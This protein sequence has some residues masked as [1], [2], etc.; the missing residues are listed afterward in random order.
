MGCNNTVDC[1]GL[2]HTHYRTVH[3][4]NRVCSVEDCGK[5]VQHGGL[6]NWHYKKYL[7]KGKT[8]SRHGCDAVVS[9]I[10][11]CYTHYMYVLNEGKVCSLDDCNDPVHRAGMCTTHHSRLRK[12]G[13]PL[14][15]G[16]NG[17]ASDDSAFVYLV[18]SSDYHAFKIG[19]G[20]DGSG[21]L[22]KHFRY[23]WV[24]VYLW[25]GF[26]GSTAYAAEKAVLNYVRNELGLP[27][28]CLAEDM[29]QTGSH[30]TFPAAGVDPFEIER[31]VS[32]VIISSRS[33][34]KF[35]QEL[36]DIDCS[37]C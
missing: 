12:H 35:Q 8:C 31:I 20:K 16:H 11:L 37:V 5:V 26:L 2:C 21:R 7:S 4:A 9:A 13:D 17:L 24:E 6:C 32:E 14:I 33:I 22:V 15:R 18:Y 19:V 28:A 36:V 25:R 29:P 10:G 34:G 30:E 23:G 27:E 1:A 3:N